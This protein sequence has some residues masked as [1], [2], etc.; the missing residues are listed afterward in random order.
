VE[1]PIKIRTTWELL[2]DSFASFNRNL[3]YYFLASILPLLFLY[4]GTVLWISNTGDFNILLIT[5]ILFVFI[6]G[7]T[8]LLSFELFWD[9]KPDLGELVR[10]LFRNSIRFFLTMCLYG[11]GIII[12]P[13]LFILLIWKTFQFLFSTKKTGFLPALILFVS[14]IFL[15][16]I[17][18][19]T[20]PAFAGIGIS[21][22]FLV[23]FSTI[24]VLATPFIMIF[25]TPAI[26]LL[27]RGGLLSSFV[28]ST[29]M[30]WGFYLHILPYVL[31][32]MT[33]NFLVI[34]TG[35][36]IASLLQNTFGLNQEFFPVFITGIL[37]TI[38][39]PYFIHLRTFYFTDIVLK[40]EG[41]DSLLN[42]RYQQ[43]LFLK[44]YQKEKAD[45]YFSS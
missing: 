24:F 20:V 8:L 4:T 14:V 19:M 37:Y 36:M 17:L 29:S 12:L 18:L 42:I 2:K 22:F 41:Y 30:T 1:I 11:L 25:L 23:I 6:Y 26:S 16:P 40:K 15:A 3:S 34:L 44:G 7:L 5:A 33:T 43:K 32:K 28:R 31:L 10:Y 9:G 38:T 39:I 45:Y 35:V 27:E 21:L 13:I